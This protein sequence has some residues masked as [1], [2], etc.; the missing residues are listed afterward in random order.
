MNGQ[1]YTLENGYKKAYFGNILSY[2][3]LLLLSTSI[4]FGVAIENINIYKKVCFISMGIMLLSWIIQSYVLCKKYDPF[5]Y[6]YLRKHKE[7]QVFM[8]NFILPISNNYLI[9]LALLRSNIY[10]KLLFKK[11][12]KF[13]RLSGI[14]KIFFSKEFPRE[15]SFLHLLVCYIF[16]FSG[17][18]TIVTAIIFIYCHNKFL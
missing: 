17:L 4:F 18:V 3:I 7:A 16:I 12:D 11:K 15:P 2:L 8:L 5:L 14:N 9:K 6:S 1:K 13:L 10:V